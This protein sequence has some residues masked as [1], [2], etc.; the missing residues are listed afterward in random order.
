MY[1]DTLGLLK[2]IGDVV[3]LCR[4]DGKCSE[5]WN[6]MQLLNDLQDIPLGP[7][8]ETPCRLTN[9]SLSVCLLRILFHEYLLSGESRFEENVNIWL[10][11]VVLAPLAS[12]TTFLAFSR[13]A[14]KPAFIVSLVTLV[15]S[16][17][18]LV[19]DLV[20]GV[21]TKASLAASLAF[22]KAFFLQF[23]FDPVLVSQQG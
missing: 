10:A 12:S 7:S 23:S 9:G 5:Q 3:L 1:V 6:I 18:S 11:S 15:A 19:S 13:S 21:F 2:Y 4:I 20:S 14:W 16:L 22:S 17:A 8:R